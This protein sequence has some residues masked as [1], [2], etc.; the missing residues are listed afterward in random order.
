MGLPSMESGLMINKRA[1]VENNGQMELFLLV[2]T[3]KAKNR[4]RDALNGP[5]AVNMMVNLRIIQ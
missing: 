4:A 5:M 3:K 1:M 2:N